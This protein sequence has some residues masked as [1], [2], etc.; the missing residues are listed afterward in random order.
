[1]RLI[2]HNG[3]SS[4]SNLRSFREGRKVIVQRVEGNRHFL[5]EAVFNGICESGASLYV[6][7]TITFNGKPKSKSINVKT[8]KGEFAMYEPQPPAKGKSVGVM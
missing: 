6:Q 1:M 7:Y 5:D 2:Y 3:V 4:K 8:H